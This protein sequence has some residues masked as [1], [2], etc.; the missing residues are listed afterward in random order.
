MSHVQ[1]DSDRQSGLCVTR[2]LTVCVMQQ[3][4]ADPWIRLTMQS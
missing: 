4:L 2:T 3:P 1:M